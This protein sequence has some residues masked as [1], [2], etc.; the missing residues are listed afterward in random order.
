LGNDIHVLRQTCAAYIT[1]P[2]RER[3][4]QRKRIAE[5]E[6]TL[7]VQE[8]EANAKDAKLGKA[9]KAKEL[10]VASATSIVL[11]AMRMIQKKGFRSLHLERQR[12][13]ALISSQANTAELGRYALDLKVL[14]WFG[15]SALGPHVLQISRG[16]MS[17]SAEQ[18]KSVYRTVKQ[19]LKEYPHSLPDSSQVAF[20]FKVIKRIRA[21]SPSSEASVRAT[22]GLG[23]P[24]QPAGMTPAA[25][26]SEERAALESQVRW[27][28]DFITGKELQRQ[29]QRALLERIS[30][31]NT[32]GNTNGNS[33]TRD[34]G[35]DDTAAN[36]LAVKLK[37]AE[38]TSLGGEGLDE[39]AE[40]D[41]ARAEDLSTDELT[42]NEHGGEN[43]GSALSAE[44]S[45]DVAAAGAGIQESPQESST[46][47]ADGINGNIYPS[48]MKAA[49]AAA[50]SVHPFFERQLLVRRMQANAQRSVLDAITGAI[51]GVVGTTATSSMASGERQAAGAADSPNT[52]AEDTQASTSFVSAFSIRTVDDL[53]WAV[54]L[55]L[56]SLVGFVLI[57]AAIG[58]AKNYRDA[59]DDSWLETVDLGTPSNGKKR[60]TT[61]KQQPGALRR[62]KKGTTT[63]KHQNPTTFVPNF[64]NVRNSTTSETKSCGSSNSATA[65]HSSCSL[66]ATAD[67]VLHQQCTAD[68]EPQ[69]LLPQQSQAAQAATVQQHAMVSRVSKENLLLF[70][71]QLERDN[72]HK[73]TN[74]V[75]HSCSND[76][77]GLRESIERENNATKR[78]PHKPKTCKGVAES[79]QANGTSEKKVKRSNSLSSASSL[80]YS[81]ASLD[82]PSLA[83]STARDVHHHCSRNSSSQLASSSSQLA[84][85]QAPMPPPVSAG[86]VFA[87][88]SS[89]PTKTATSKTNAHSSDATKNLAASVRHRGDVSDIRVPAACCHVT[90]EGSSHSPAEKRNATV[91]TM[92]GAGSS[93]FASVLRRNLGPTET[94]HR[95]PAVQTVDEPPCTGTMAH[96]HC[97]PFCPPSSPPLPSG[98][99]QLVDGPEVRTMLRPVLI[100]A[101]YSL[102]PSESLCV[103]LAPGQLVPGYRLNAEGSFVTGSREWDLQGALGMKKDDATGATDAAA[104]AASAAGETVWQVGILLPA[105]MRNLH[106]KF[107]LVDNDNQ[108]RYLEQPEAPPRTMELEPPTLEEQQAAVRR[109]AEHYF[110]ANN[111]CKD[112]FLRS[113][114]DSEGFVFISVIAKFN[115]LQKLCGGALGLT[116]VVAAL[117]PSDKLQLGRV[118]PRAKTQAPTHPELAKVRMARGPR[119]F[120]LPEAAPSECCPLEAAC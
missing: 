116:D 34:L 65:D 66:L 26:V 17:K 120:V 5:Q 75:E 82:C 88:P 28:D 57:K 72:R 105:G 38:E 107:V 7:A 71:K 52:P 87:T 109:Q 113:H 18:Q 15:A 73:H 50:S 40:D 41:D 58:E 56:G 60:S 1:S 61:P 11:R 80:A 6:K 12:L 81:E 111:L 29:K 19:L 102:K 79:E 27:I 103:A 20:A 22:Q 63:P 119:K 106:F 112:I 83:P 92:W 114:M 68:A 54:M 3:K 35:V 30:N 78:R 108:T 21:S 53:D 42:E 31:G 89:R 62:R 43:Q 117:E 37:Q 84:S 24:F 77:H 45:G 13:T 115:M 101:H 70:T 74:C 100:Q 118:P 2:R 48:G 14:S 110:S 86:S 10:T 76:G 55:I 98:P 94:V 4:E 104:A 59:N 32:N 47:A 51:T 67:R 91:P 69:Q 96:E 16:F 25:L 44:K 93:S 64:G 49:A 97:P 46:L 9:V 90:E 39:L 23:K 8:A 95:P 36:E 33:D 99:L 85:S